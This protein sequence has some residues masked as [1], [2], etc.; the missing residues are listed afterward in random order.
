[1]IVDPSVHL[2]SITS[3]F[4]WLYSSLLSKFLGYHNWPIHS[5][6]QYLQ[7]MALGPLKTF[8][9]SLSVLFWAY[10]IQS[11]IL[12]AMIIDP[13][14]HVSSIASQFHWAHSSL[15][16]KL[17]SYHDWPICSCW[18]CLQWM[19]WASSSLSVNP[20]PTI[21]YQQPSELWY[22]AH[23]SIS[24]VLLVHLTSPIQEIQQFWLWAHLV[25]GLSWSHGL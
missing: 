4:N 22:L 19:L 13:S 2:G 12:S 25:C 8:S 23:L 5:C 9:S 17:L 11:T 20:G 10:H 7:W 16:L 24:A 18:Q 14:V 15:L 21:V 6:W 1:M 3:W